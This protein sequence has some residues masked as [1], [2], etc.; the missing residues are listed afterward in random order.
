MVDLGNRILSQDNKKQLC[1]LHVPYSW[2]SQNQ[3]VQ[4]SIRTKTADLLE[5]YFTS[6]NS[7]GHFERPV[8]PSK[9]LTLRAPPPSYSF[10]QPGSATRLGCAMLLLS[11]LKIPVGLCAMTCPQRLNGEP[12]SLAQ[13]FPWPKELLA[14]Q[15]L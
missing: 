3:T 7:Q 6:S 2:T 14:P 1:Q 13:T 9:P 8:I 11:V 12:K 5:A 15:W 10:P 4:T